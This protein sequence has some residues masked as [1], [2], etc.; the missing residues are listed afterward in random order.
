MSA[1][2]HIFLYVDT[3][4][5]S[6]RAEET[7][8]VSSESRVV[9]YA[10]ALSIKTKR[11]WRIIFSQSCMKKPNGL[12]IKKVLSSPLTKGRK[13]FL[14]S[15]FPLGQ[16]KNLLPPHGIKGTYSPSHRS[17]V[18]W[19]MINRQF[20]WLGFFACSTFPVSQWHPELAPPYS[21]GTVSAFNRLLY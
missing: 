5:C 11:S 14:S 21:G 19:W 12:I 20:S 9:I 4:G 7:S 2:L 8:P 3:G 1:H 15:F 18:N 17:Q 16:I 6:Y 10:Q 13:S